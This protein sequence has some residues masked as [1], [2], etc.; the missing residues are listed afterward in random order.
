MYIWYIMSIMKKYI[1]YI[2]SILCGV[3]MFSSCGSAKLSVANEQYA[4]G[5]YYEA[6]QTY[7]KVYNKLQ[8]KADRPLRGQVAYMMAI[9]IVASI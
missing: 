9:V 2:L 6:A 8:K 7:R 5:E 1:V 3:V 4:R